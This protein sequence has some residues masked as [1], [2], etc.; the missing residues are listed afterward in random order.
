MIQ[1]LKVLLLASFVLC[2]SITTEAQSQS[3]SISEGPYIFYKGDQV[4]VRWV[5]NGQ[6][7]EAE[8]PD[9]DFLQTHFKLGIGPEVFLQNQ[10]EEPDFLQEYKNVT[11]LALIS[12]IHGQ[13]GLAVNLLQAHGIIDENTDWKFGKGHLV[14]NGDVL[15]RGDMVTEVLWLVYKLEHQAKK[16]GGMVHFLVGNHELMFIENDMRFLNEKYVTASGIMGVSPSAFY[17]EEAVLGN[18]LRKRPVIITIDDLLI[19]HAGISPEFIQRNLTSKKVNKVFYKNILKS[20]NR[21]KNETQIF[22]TG[23]TGPL[24]YRSYFIQPSPSQQQLAE[25]LDHFDS[26]KIVVGHTSLGAITPLYEGKV[27]GIDANIKEGKTG[28][29]LIIQNGEAFRGRTDGS[30]IKL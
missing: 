2:F 19:T 25:I 20:S 1:N 23:E 13:Y 17:G 4:A 24:W 29:I 21:R 16:Q 3:N 9:A 10:N 14:V 6:M 7:K 8:N 5:D 27:I 11:N 22:L 18:W 12:D 30:R 26:Q 28:E 15:G